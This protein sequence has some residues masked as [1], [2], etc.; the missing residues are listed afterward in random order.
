MFPDD[1]FWNLGYPT[2]SPVARCE[3]VCWKKLKRFGLQSAKLGFKALLRCACI[4]AGV[5]PNKR[6]RQKCHITLGSGV[7]PASCRRGG[8]GGI[9]SGQ[10]RTQRHPQSCFFSPSFSPFF[11]SFFFPRP[12]AVCAWRALSRGK[13]ALQRCRARETGGK[14]Q[15]TRDEGGNP[16]DNVK[17]FISPVAALPRSP[18]PLFEPSRICFCSRGLKWEQCK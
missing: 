11:F 12:F 3:L 1:R 16:G 13:R 7:P 4:L 8:R 14:E 9:M 2:G 15:K 10:K 17:Y 18:S 5:A 6:P